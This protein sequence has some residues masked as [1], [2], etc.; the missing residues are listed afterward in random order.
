[1]LTG[2]PCKRCWSRPW[3]LASNA[4]IS[5]FS[6]PIWYKNCCTAKASPVVWLACTKAPRRPLPAVPITALLMPV[7]WVS[8]ATNWLMVVLPLVPVTATTFGRVTGCWYCK[9]AWIKLP[10]KSR[11]L[12]T[13][14]IGHGS[15]ANCCCALD[16]PSIFRGVFASLIKAAGSISERTKAAF[17][18]ACSK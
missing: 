1:M 8:C 12:G 11:I 3:E 16:S 7:N 10:K 5:A 17:S 9:Y 4:N 6:V 14:K 2:T 18:A 13:Y 15:A